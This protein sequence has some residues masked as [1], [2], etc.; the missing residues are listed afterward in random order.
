MSFILWKLLLMI[1]K[2]HIWGMADGK[3]SLGINQMGRI[4]ITHGWCHHS[5]RSAETCL[6][7]GGEF[8]VS[9]KQ[10]RRGWVV[11]RLWGW[12]DEDSVLPTLACAIHYSVI[13]LF[14]TNVLWAAGNKTSRS[15]SLLGSR[16]DLQNQLALMVA[17]VNHMNR[18]EGGIISRS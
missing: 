16:A 2:P 14:L 6:S 13:P 11:A 4:H 3:I 10:I 17:I 7:K 8:I 12:L 1:R 9:H 15:S 5:P 18:M